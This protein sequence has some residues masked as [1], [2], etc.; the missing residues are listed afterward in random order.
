[1]T[2]SEFKTRY[3]AS[4]PEVPEELRE[5]LGLERFVQFDSEVVSALNLSTRDAAIL[6]DVGLPESASPWL[7]F[8]MPPKRQLKPMDGFPEMLAIGTNAYGDHVCLDK[9]ANGE[10]VY[11]NHDNLNARVLINSSVSALAESLCLYLTHRHQ[12]EPDDLLAAIA[13]IDP[14]A[15]VHDTFWHYEAITL[16]QRDE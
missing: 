7:T 5:E 8:R 13:A 12:G 16:A 14:P 9:N 11:V 4:L 10:V 3:I 6:I 15:I 1:M 2:P